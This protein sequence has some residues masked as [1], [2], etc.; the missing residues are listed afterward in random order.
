M[1]K[2]GTPASPAIALAKRVLPVPGGPTSSTPL[3]IFA[4]I[5]VNFSGSLR[6]VTISC[7]SSF[8]SSIQATSSKE[9]PVVASI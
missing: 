1:L 2:K 8:A 9:I 6:K 7:N 5:A 3:G 4:P